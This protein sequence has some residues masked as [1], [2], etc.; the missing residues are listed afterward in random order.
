M[1]I[2][3]PNFSYAL[4]KF[5]SH[6]SEEVTSPQVTLNLG[7]LLMLNW[8]IAYGQVPFIPENKN[9]SP[10]LCTGPALENIW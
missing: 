5:K 1:R 10:V 4:R 7:W 2:W 8:N 3:L 9:T 6:V